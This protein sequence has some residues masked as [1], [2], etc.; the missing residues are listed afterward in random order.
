MWSRMANDFLD[1]CSPLLLWSCL[2]SPCPDIKGSLLCLLA[3][4]HLGAHPQECGPLVTLGSSFVASDSCNLF[5]QAMQFENTW[6]HAWLWGPTLGA[7]TL[8]MCHL[9]ELTDLR[10]PLQVLLKW[11]ICLTVHWAVMVKSSLFTTWFHWTLQSSYFAP[12]Y[13]INYFLF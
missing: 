8:P 3:M 4:C 7:C 12:A 2:S 10:D 9:G 6:S 5:G 13:S 11:M 1:P